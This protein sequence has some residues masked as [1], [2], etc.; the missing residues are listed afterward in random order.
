MPLLCNN[1]NNTDLY[2]LHYYGCD[3]STSNN[4]FARHSLIQLKSTLL[5]ESRYQ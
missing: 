2:T 1:N 5:F 3:D 4:V